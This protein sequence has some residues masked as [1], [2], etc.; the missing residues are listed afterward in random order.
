MNPASR[1]IICVLKG[2]CPLKD[3]K[4]LLLDKIKAESEWIVEIFT[5]SYAKEAIDLARDAA[6]RATHIIAVGGDG[7]LHEVVNGM[8]QGRSK[9]IFG[10]IPNGTGND[11]QRNFG[12]WDENTWWNAFK[13]ERTTQ[14]DLCKVESEDQVHYA[15]NIAGCGFDGHVV[16]LLNRQRDKWKLK[17]K[18]SYAT[19]I[20][21]AF[22]TY[23]KPLIRI[24]SEEFYWEGN[25]L[26]VLA[27]KGTTFGHG[28]TIA[29]EARLNSAYIHCVLLG[30]VSL[31]DYVRN[32]GRLKK[33]SKISHPE[34]HYFQTKQLKI[35]LQTGQLWQESDGELKGSGSLKITVEPA[36]LR[37]LQ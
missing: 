29:P 32:L 36:A 21:R 1:H 15:L 3:G 23:R 27:C 37:V 35:E 14:V 25:A 8:M 30:K 9:A 11:Y 19:A 20:V 7:T 22:F 13:N 31:L 34:A 10:F 28:L 26:M 6:D 5:T 16:N 4:R 17:G 24:Q 33:G 18:M 12:R 2:N